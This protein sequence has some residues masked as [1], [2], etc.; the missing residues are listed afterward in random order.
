MTT[1]STR[2][3]PRGASPDVTRRAGTI[4]S[5]YGW[6][7]L[8]RATSPA[9][10]ARR[11]HEPRPPCQQ[12]TMETTSST[13]RAYGRASWAYRDTAGSTSM[14]AA[15]SRPSRRPPSRVASTAVRATAVQAS[16]DSSRSHRSWF[17]SGPRSSPAGSREPAPG[18]R[19][20]VNRIW[21]SGR[22]TTITVAGLVA[23]PGGQPAPAP[24]P[25]A[26]VPHTA[27]VMPGRSPVDAARVRNRR[28]DHPTTDFPGRAS[29]RIAPPQRSGPHARSRTGGAHHA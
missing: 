28:G 12:S 20:S 5:P 2:R 24:A 15:A 18:R 14:A 11:R 8:S 21:D 23:G 19:G 10:P 1:R 26:A 6:I 25:T 29:R 22:R 27:T 9:R 16:T 3:R 7:R 13:L 4:S 17:R